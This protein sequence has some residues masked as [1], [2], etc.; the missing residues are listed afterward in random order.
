MAQK[1]HPP[2]LRVTFYWGIIIK[3]QISDLQMI[4]HPLIHV[5]KLAL[6]HLIVA[7]IFVVSSSFSYALKLEQSDYQINPIAGISIFED[8][9]NRLSIHDIKSLNFQNR[10]IAV[11]KSVNQLNFGFSDS[12]Y[13]LKVSLERTSN[14]PEIWILQIPYFGLD[15]IDFFAPYQ[16]AVYTGTARPIESR[17]IFGRYYA[18]PLILKSEQAQNI[19]IRVKS[20]SSLS[21]P[22]VLW[23]PEAYSKNSLQDSFLQSFYYGGIG[24]LCIFNLLI[25]IY[26]R[27]KA[28]FYYSM[29]ALFVGLGI[30]SGNGY[31]RLFL[32]PEFP[33]W[34]QISQVLFL[35]IAAGNAMLFTKAFLNT[36]K[37][38]P[39]INAAMI[40]CSCLIYAASLGM[41]ASYM[42]AI[43]STLFLQLLPLLSLP[44]VFLAILSGI[45]AFRMNVGSAKFF[46]LAW[47]ALSLGAVIA[48]LRMFD[49][50]PSNWLTSYALQISSAVEMLLLSFALANRIK[51]ERQMREKAQSEVL[52]SRKILVDS[53][54]AS[55]DRLERTVE[56][57][58]QDLREMFEGEKRLREQYVRFG[59]MIS[60]EFRN[61]LGIIETQ[62]ALMSHGGDQEK[63]EKRLS[64]IG[65]ATHR[66]AMLFD[67][68]LQGDRL[69]SKIDSVR[70][71]LLDLDVWLE[72]LVNKCASYHLEHQIKLIGSD[73][74]FTLMADEKMLQALVLNL[75][76]N[77]CKYSSPKSVVQVQIMHRIGMVGISV[78]DQGIGIAPENHAII[79]NEYLQLNSNSQ[80]RG[81]GLGLAFVK[82]IV[83]L[84][85]GTVEL[86][87]ELG[88]GSE[89]IA[90]FPEKSMTHLQTG[91]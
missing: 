43:E 57:R 84:H 37:I 38:L 42:F 29:F 16:T 33:Q 61:P 90:W 31:G 86:S 10:F 22:I 8:V 32:W 62:L 36:K 24:V 89:F 58:T 80:T 30:F 54:K 6:R 77:A 19:Y 52:E 66:L 67:R 51:D 17:P 28:Y 44:G 81:F 25:F 14:A 15:N 55:E 71:Q 48:V 13:W 21:I 1:S 20:R 65:S 27:D 82:R 9:T 26:L 40:V 68:W 7:L 60:H 64:T 41:F 35:G 23:Q 70:P 76:D 39:R 69:D 12:A 75:I 59:S 3:H 79:F 63:L 56:V 45:L 2:S 53:L 50:V 78:K 49:L 73:R 83:E 47:G 72:E 34:D 87:S 5:R 88:I 4:P 11:P 18:F 46:L 85:Q 91:L 74:R